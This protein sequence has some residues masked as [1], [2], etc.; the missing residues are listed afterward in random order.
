MYNNDRYKTDL[1]F[2]EKYERIVTPKLELLGYYF[3][4]FACLAAH[5]LYCILF[6]R[7]GVKIMSGFNVFSVIFYALMLIGVKPVKE[8]L[9]L[10]YATL[11]E[12]IIHAAL[13]TVCVGV[14]PDFCMFLLMIIPLTFLMPNKNPNIPFVVMFVSVSLYG[15][16]R[17]IFQEPGRAIYMVEDIPLLVTLYVINII[18]GSFVLIYVATIYTCSKHYKECKINVQN[19]Q[20]KIMASTDP[21]TKLNNRREINIKLSDICAKSREN[22][23]HFVV[24]IADIDDFKKVND[25]YGHDYGDVVL[26]SVAAVIAGSLPQNGCAARWGGEE[27]LFVL[28][29]TGIEDGLACAEKIIKAV[30]AQKFS[31]DSA[32][33]FVTMTAGICECAPGDY[34]DRLIS[35]ADARLY[36]GKYSGK[37]CVVYED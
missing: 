13:A 18:V 19:E 20:L 2:I 5:I 25:I 36:K 30:R 4:F 6:S 26:A 11:A 35:R 28:P 1:S 34:I 33:F 24:G 21:L 3:T 12:I 29:D 15:I 32:D 37:N 31:H 9:D 7:A 27:F 16:L 17:Y 22:G 8:K 14:I 23:K 10:A